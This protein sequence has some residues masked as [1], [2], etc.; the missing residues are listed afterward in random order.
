MATSVR[1]RSGLRWTLTV[2]AAVGLL[3]DAFVHF[4]LAGS[5]SSVK[6]NL[7]TEG[8]LFR[9][10]A[11]VATL[12]AIALLVRPRRYTA[13]IAF[14]VAA[15]GTAAV[16][17]TRYV[18]VGAFGPIPSM[19]DP[20]WYTEKTLSAVAEGIAAIAALLLFLLLH[21]EARDTQRATA[22]S[23]G[24]AAAPARG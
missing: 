22:Q 18:K 2:I 14:V 11:V 12:A 17:F 8:D 9:V 6:T 20:I 19:Y 4:H 21:S 3:I 15:G 24:S 23:D 1:N 5:Y 13:A 7:L 16:V 10:E